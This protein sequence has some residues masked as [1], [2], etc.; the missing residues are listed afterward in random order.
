[1]NEKAC[2]YP[3]SFWEQ[4][5]TDWRRGAERTDR[6]KTHLLYLDK[7]F[8]GKTRKTSSDRFIFPH[9][10]VSLH[11]FATCSL[12]PLPLSPSFTSVSKSPMRV[13]YQTLFLS[14]INNISVTSQKPLTKLA[15][16][17]QKQKNDLYRT[18]CVASTKTSDSLLGCTG[19]S[20]PALPSFFCSSGEEV[21]YN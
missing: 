7:F 6:K 3:I 2:K 15:I 13:A 1:M 14:S 18:N 19:S 20:I 16:P 5:D 21:C 10:S 17:T 9:L 4:R 12:F 11:A 8:R